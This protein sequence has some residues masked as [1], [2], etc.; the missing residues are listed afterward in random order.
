MDKLYLVVVRIKLLRFGGM[1]NFDFNS[2]SDNF[3]NLKLKVIFL[4]LQSI[5]ESWGKV[6][7]LP[8]LD[9]ERVGVR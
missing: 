4:L 1:N 5:G 2:L 6:I 3:E 8:L 9:K 7:F